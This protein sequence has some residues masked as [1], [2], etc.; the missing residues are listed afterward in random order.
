MKNKI[1]AQIRIDSMIDIIT[2][3]SSELFVIKNCMEIEM[4]VDLVNKSLNDS[5]FH[6]TESNVEKRIAKDLAEYEVD[7]KITEA[8]ELFPEDKRDEI[9]E[10]YLTEPNYYG[11]AFDRDHIY[12]SDTDVRGILSKIGFELIDTDY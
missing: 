10:K 11:I 8:L 5:Q 9:K 3:S 6:I 7:W 4:I 1:I 12:S 2:N